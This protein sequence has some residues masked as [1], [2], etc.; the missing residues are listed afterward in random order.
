MI[1]YALFEILSTQVSPCIL[2]HAV[3]L[4]STI[5]K[6]ARIDI[7]IEAPLTIAIALSLTVN[8]STLSL[9]SLSAFRQANQVQFTPNV[10]NANIS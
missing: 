10:R 9:G 4:L 5:R 7:Q 8:S 3:K 6:R 2:S 1:V